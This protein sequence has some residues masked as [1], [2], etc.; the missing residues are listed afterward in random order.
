M[1]IDIFKKKDSLKHTSDF[2]Y[3]DFSYFD[4]LGVLTIE[5]IALDF[6]KEEFQEMISK[7]E[8]LQKH[9]SL[10]SLTILKPQE[11]IVFK[12]KSQLKRSVINFGVVFKVAAVISF[13]VLL[14]YF[15]L[16]RNSNALEMYSVN[17]NLKP[18]DVVELVDIKE[19]AIEKKAEKID[20]KTTVQESKKVL[21][22]VVVET[23]NYSFND[24]EDELLIGF[25][26]DTLR[27]FDVIG[28][29]KIQFAVVEPNFEM[30]NLSEK[31]HILGFIGKKLFV[32]SKNINIAVQRNE[33]GGFASLTIT[34]PDKTYSVKKL[35]P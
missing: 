33:D 3:K 35:T 6:E 17:R 22:K 27:V 18:R 21:E 9:A 8:K 24:S 7:D 26:P 15:Y 30:N 32:L 28:Q 31:K 29:E 2:D 12:K 14:S 1:K 13:L 5:N 16:Y 10:Y 19:V 11:D 4:R 34:T 25:N 20:K 23:E